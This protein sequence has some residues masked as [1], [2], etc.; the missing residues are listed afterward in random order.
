[1]ALTSIGGGISTALADGATA[2]DKLNGTFTAINGTIGATLTLIPGF[3]PALNMV[4]QGVTSIGKAILQATGM[5]D[6]FED[7][8]K[9]TA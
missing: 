7:R 8:F 9:S 4:W 2:A 5:W 1:M 3:G 6:K